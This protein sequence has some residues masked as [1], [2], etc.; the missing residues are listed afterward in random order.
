MSSILFHYMLSR[1][2]QTYVCR[3]PASRWDSRWDLSTCFQCWN[4]VNC[5]ETQRWYYHDSLGKGFIVCMVVT[6]VDDV[7]VPSRVNHRSSSESS[8][9]FS[10]L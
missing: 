8:E 5:I 10:P 9:T 6:V 2:P 7:A 3:T 4:P 1:P